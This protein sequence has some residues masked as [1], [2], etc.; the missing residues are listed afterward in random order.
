M[1]KIIAAFTLLLLAVSFYSAYGADPYGFSNSNLKAKVITADTLK[2]GGVTFSGVGMSTAAFKDSASHYGLS[3]P[4]TFTDSLLTKLFKTAVRD[5]ANAAISANTTLLPKVSVR[6]SANAAIAVNTTLLPKSVFPDSATAALARDTTKLNRS[7]FNDSV[8]AGLIRDTTKLP[9]SAVRDSANAA[10][11]AN[12]TL[13]PKVNFAD[14]I[15]TRQRTIVPLLWSTAYG[16]SFFA[17]DSLQVLSTS[18]GPIGTA[19]SLFAQPSPPSVTVVEKVRMTVEH[20]F[21]NTL[22][23]PDSLRTKIW[24][25][26]TNGDDFVAFYVYGDSI[27]TAF[28]SK[29]DTSGALYSSS[30]RTPLYISLA[31]PKCTN[32]GGKIRVEAVIQMK[33]SDSLFIAPVEIVGTNR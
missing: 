19:Q 14:S 18:K 15:K 16:D 26:R 2:V 5:S 28:N 31:L 24:T 17:A 23:K 11:A 20:L 29:P 30:A 1:K 9:K 21:F 22:F 3:K 6:D 27:S 10:I 12:T 32:L 33:N 13:L 7:A 25:E 8:L 4:S